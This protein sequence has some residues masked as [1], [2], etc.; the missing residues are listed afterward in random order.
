MKVID[1]KEEISEDLFQNDKK[2]CNE[3]ILVVTNILI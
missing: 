3:L 1:V 2:I